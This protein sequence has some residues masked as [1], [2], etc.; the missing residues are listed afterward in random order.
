M[1]AGR[2]DPDVHPSGPK[3]HV[4]DIISNMSNAWFTELLTDVCNEPFTG[5]NTFPVGTL[6]A[7][8]NGGLR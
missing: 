5:G 4:R 6:T 3:M 1:I 7:E 2:H 8:V